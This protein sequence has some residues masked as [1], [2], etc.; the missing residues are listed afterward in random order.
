[1]VISNC[2][3]SLGDDKHLVLV[4]AAHVLSLRWPLR[5]LRRRRWAGCIAGALSPEAVLRASK[6]CVAARRID[7]RDPSGTHRSSQ[8]YHSRHKTRR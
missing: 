5:H 3:V 6:E 8:R 4:E 1:M 2:V 7:H